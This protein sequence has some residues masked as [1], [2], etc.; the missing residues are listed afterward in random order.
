MFGIIQTEYFTN[1][2]TDKIYRAKTLE[3]LPP[4]FSESYD[5]VLKRGITKEKIDESWTKVDTLDNFGT[6]WLALASFHFLGKSLTWW[7]G[8]HKP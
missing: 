2:V 6:L 5:L 8:I 1:T 4:H 3:S 7:T